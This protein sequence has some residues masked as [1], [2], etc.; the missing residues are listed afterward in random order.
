VLYEKDFGSGQVEKFFNKIS[1]LI[2]ELEVEGFAKDKISHM[3]QEKLEELFFKSTQGDKKKVAFKTMADTE[4]K[5]R[6]QIAINNEKK[7]ELDQLDNE[8]D[9]IQAKAFEM[10]GAAEEIKNHYRIKNKLLAIILFVLA[11][12]VATGAVVYLIVQKK[13]VN[14]LNEELPGKVT[15]KNDSKPIPSQSTE[16]P[17]KPSKAHSL[18]PDL[19]L[20]NLAKNNKPDKMTLIDVDSTSKGF[21]SKEKYLERNL[22]IGSATLADKGPVRYEIGHQK[23]SEILNE[24]QNRT[25]E[26]TKLLHG[27]IINKKSNLI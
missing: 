20:V 27:N 22:L 9:D 5:L 24:E 21:E 26:V 2:N 19:E 17:V 8:M 18:P 7:Q 3:I 11:I 16:T 25:L 13:Q 15:V 23:N 6:N 4:D 10:E 1:N 12:A 14:H